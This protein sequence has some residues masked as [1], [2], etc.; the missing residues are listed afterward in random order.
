MKDFKEHPVEYEFSQ[1]KYLNDINSINN[2]FVCVSRKNRLIAVYEIGLNS[3]PVM[4][5]KITFDSYPENIFLGDVNNDRVFEVLV[6]GIG[7]DGLSILMRREGRLAENKIISGESFNQAVLADLSNDGY[8]DVTAFNILNNSTQ[9]FYN[10]TYGKFKLVRKTKSTEKIELLNQCD[11][12]NDD[13]NDLIFN[14]GTGLD[15]VYGD[16]QSAYD[17]KKSFQ[18][19]NKPL[20]LQFNDFNGDS[21]TDIAYINPE[22]GNINVLFAKSGHEFYEEIT[23][24]NLPSVS[25]I[26]NFKHK[27]NNNLIILSKNGIVTTISSFENDLNSTQV[28][29][30]INAAVL[31]KFDLNRDGISDICFI[32]KSDNTFRILTR[33]SNWIFSDLYL[34]NLAEPH[35]SIVVDDFFKVRKTFYCYSKENQLIEFLQINFKTNKINHK[36]LYSPGKIKDLTIQR[37]DSSLVNIYLLY[38][39]GSKLYLGKFEH[40][41]LSLTFKEYP[42]IDRDVM[43]AELFVDKEIRAF[44]WKEKSDSLFF[45]EVIVKTGPNIYSG[46]MGLSKKD[47]IKISITAS[48]QLYGGKPWVI[49]LIGNDNKNF[50]ISFKENSY[51]K[52]QLLNEASKIDYF[53]NEVFTFAKLQYDENESLLIYIPDSKSLNKL[54]IS[55]DGKNYSLKQIVDGVDINS[56]FIDKFTRTNY[57][58][59]YSDKEKG[60]ISVLQLKR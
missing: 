58:L 12:N 9:F 59:V 10:D 32:D 23:Y 45:N 6:S 25:C 52:L 17:K 38:V 51:K 8:A 28:I 57:H 30:A 4:K 54:S 46:I 41:D 21:F 40:R 7:F 29:P 31:Q 60:C 56:Y 43:C 11:F 26:A 27:K 35:Q 18:L 39:K 20:A 2:R 50:L 24:T 1:I 19:K 13:L 53:K 22:T 49:S 5:S 3:S 48:N 55:N 33:N 34:Q 37:V 14:Y 16:F 36:H 47:S 15:I 42:F 44:Y